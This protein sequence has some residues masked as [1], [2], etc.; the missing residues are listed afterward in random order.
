MRIIGIVFWVLFTVSLSVW[1]LYFGLTQLELLEGIEGTEKVITQQRMLIWEGISLV[2][3]ILIG[4]GALAY[5]AYSER[6][7]RKRIEEFFS[8]FSHELKTPLTNIQLQAESLGANKL[9]ESTQ[10]LLVH[11]DNAMFVAKLPD[12]LFHEEVEL[13]SF[14]R[15]LARRWS[16]LDIDCVGDAVIEIDKRIFEA[17]FQNLFSNSVIHGSASRVEIKI[18]DCKDDV[19]ISFSD[20]GIGFKGDFS[21][22]GRKFYRSS[23]TSG[24]GLGLY[25]VKELLNKMGGKISFKEQKQGFIAQITIPKSI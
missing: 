16:S 23:K 10:R 17:I 18:D 21:K 1:W 4:G 12:K 11:L 9:I 24:S 8:V 25:I 15:S 6:K 14:I 3:S 22:L 20:N 7:E 19:T 13:N 2:V 5:L